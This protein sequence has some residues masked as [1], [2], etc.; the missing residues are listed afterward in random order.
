MV[1]LLALRELPCPTPSK[2]GIKPG[3][4]A[5]PGGNWPHYLSKPLGRG[6]KGLD[7]Y[8]RLPLPI[9]ASSVKGG[10][11]Q[12]SLRALRGVTAVFWGKGRAM[13]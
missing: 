6:L 13:A 1:A 12:M 10:L 7:L 8:P 3:P 9:Q 5:K 2:R 4:R 11:D